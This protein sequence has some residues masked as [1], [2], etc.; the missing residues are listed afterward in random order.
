LA[1]A[2]VADRVRRGGHAVAEETIRRRYAAGLR[3]F[4]SL[5]QPLATS[6]EIVDNSSVPSATV[7]AGTGTEV[8]EIEDTRRWEMITGHEG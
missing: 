1:V 3:N 5:Y 7:A 6:W 4:F 2:R 8:E